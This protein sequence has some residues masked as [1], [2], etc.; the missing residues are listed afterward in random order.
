METHVRAMWH[1]STSLLNC[2]LTIAF[3]TNDTCHRVISPTQLPRH[4]F[5]VSVR[6]LYTCPLRT[7]HVNDTTMP[8]QH[9]FIINSPSHPSISVVWTCHVNT[10]QTVQSA[11]FCLF[12]KTY[13]MQYLTQL[14]YVLTHSSCG[15]FGK[16][17][18][19]HV[20]VLNQIR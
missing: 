17:R 14:T 16:T 5:H 4:V 15:R 8:C 19:T 3:L 18:P 20:S 7:C 1:H 12:G 2:H 6:P 10:V 9:L 11:K 13:R